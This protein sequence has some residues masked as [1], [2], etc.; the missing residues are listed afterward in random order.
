V[1]CLAARRTDQEP[2]AQRYVRTSSRTSGG[3]GRM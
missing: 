2:G 1:G 3:R